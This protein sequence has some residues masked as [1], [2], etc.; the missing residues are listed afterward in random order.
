MLKHDFFRVKILLLLAALAGVLALPFALRPRSEM[1]DRCGLRLVV[2]SPHNEATRHEFGIAFRAWHRALHGSDVVLDW[3]S[4]GGTSEIVRYLNA[5]Y[6]AADRAGLQGIG[7]DLFFGGG[8]YD[9]AIQ[10]EKGHTALIGLRERH[11]EWLD[12]S[13]ITQQFSGEIYYDPGDRWYGCC[14]SSFGICYNRD[15][16]RRFGVERPP[17]RWSDLA[18]PV[19]FRRLALADPTKSGSINKAFEML[20]QQQMREALFPEMNADTA[21]HSDLAA[22]WQRA[23]ALLRRIGANARYF[24]DAAGKVP[25]DVAQ[26]DAAAGMCID[27]YGRFESETVQRNEKS[28]RLVFVMP[29]AG[30]SVAVDPVS[31]LRG[32]PNRELAERFVDFALGVDGQ[33]LWNFKVGAPGGPIKYALRRLPI[34]KDVYSHEYRVH[35]SDPEAAPYSYGTGFVY[36]PE[37]TAPLFGFIRLLIR[38]MCMDPHEELAAAWAAINA[39]GGPEMCPE[40]VRAMEALPSNAEYAAARETAKLMHDKVLETRITREWFEFFQKQYVLARRLA[41]EHAAK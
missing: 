31:I 16:L 11:P 34:R 21:A 23:M 32:A 4:I 39:A 36:R 15:V 14:L 5:S 1:P 30:S 9:H 27:F 37:W 12:G 19:Y 24:T 20:I 41:E 35:M 40:A 26:G 29:Q 18:D 8:G 10:A 33:K 7:V 28:D 3:R 2:L 38:S 13:I 6:D 25:L 17:E 22:G